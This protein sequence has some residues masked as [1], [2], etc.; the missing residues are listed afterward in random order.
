MKFI[1]LI[2][3]VMAGQPPQIHHVEVWSRVH[4]EV[5]KAAVEKDYAVAFQKADL[6]YSVTCIEKTIDGREFVP[7]Y[8]K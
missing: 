1:L 5:A 7:G 8:V 3:M 4:C 2:T 6:R